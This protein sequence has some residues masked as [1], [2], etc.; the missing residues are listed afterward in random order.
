VFFFDCTCLLERVVRRQTVEQ[1]ACAT[2]ALRFAQEGAGLSFLRHESSIR[3][4]ATRDA[5]VAKRNQPVPLIWSK[6]ALLG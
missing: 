6:S 2:D 5:A 4:Y 1:Q 3:P